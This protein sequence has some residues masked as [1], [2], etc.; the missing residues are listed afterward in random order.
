[1]V[2]AAV[3][4]GSAVAGIAGSALSSSA[5]GSAADAQSG[6]ANNATR[7][8][9][10]MFN[11]VQK[12]LNPYMQFG[13]QALNPL[14]GLLGLNGSGGIDPSLMQKT[15]QNMPGYEF[16]LNQGLKSV[17]NSAAARGLGSSGAALK[18]AGTYATG[19]A[20]S[21][22]DQYYNQLL[23][24]AGL[25]ENAA[26]GVGNAAVSTGQGIAGTI[27]NAGNAQAAGILGSANG[28]NNAIGSASNGLGLY[29]LLGGSF[30]GGGGGGYNDL[31]N[32]SNSMAQMSDR[33]LKSNIRKIGALRNG[34][35]IYR[36][37][38]DGRE[39]IGLMADEVERV[40]PEAVVTMP[41]GYKGV[42]YASA[43]Q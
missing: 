5:S 13:N 21:N 17:Q 25:G 26:A 14:E 18:G 41:N 6:A 36:Y 38:I 8:Q 29:S 40:H 19:L 31:F 43:M 11:T 27:Q 30:G 23:G 7:A 4:I 28:I 32:M 22:Y 12:N 37:I 3:G 20:Q 15:L 1:M 42:I 2:A 33:R 9:L 39:D 34:L 35:S 24:A 16:T 10:Q